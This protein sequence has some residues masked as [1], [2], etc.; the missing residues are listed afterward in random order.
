MNDPRFF[1]D[2]RTAFGVDAEGK[3]RE[4]LRDL[5]LDNFNR[6]TFNSV[7]NFVG[8]TGSLADAANSSEERKA[9]LARLQQ[10]SE[11]YPG[12]FSEGG[13]GLSAVP[14][15]AEGVITD[16]LNVIPAVS[17]SAKVGKGL[18]AARSLGESFTVGR[19]LKEGAL[20]GAK[21]EGLISGAAEGL[22]S[23][24]QQSMRS[25]LGLQD[26]VSGMAV[27]EDVTL[28]ALM[29]AGVGS[30]LGAA[31]G[32][33][34]RS[35]A[36]KAYDQAIDL[37]YR[38]TE[39]MD[40][41]LGEVRQVVQNQR[42]PSPAVLASR[43]DAPQEDLTPE[44]TA[45]M[46]AERAAA[47]A[48]E[49][50]SL[51]LKQHQA[52]LR[53]LLNEYRRQV[54]FGEE[55]DADPDY[56]D[57]VKR[58]LANVR[59]A[60]EFQQ[61]TE[62]ELA[63]II[64]DEGSNKL[65]ALERA[66]KRA[67]VFEEDMAMLDAL[68]TETVPEDYG[69]F[70]RQRLEE[71]KARAEQQKAQQAEQ[72]K[73][74]KKGG[75]PRRG[76]A[77]RTTA[78]GEGAEAPTEAP[79][80]A[81]RGTGSQEGVTAPD[82]RPTEQVT[83]Q[84]PDSTP[85]DEGLDDAGTLDD[86]VARLAELERAEAEAGA[87][88]TGVIPPEVPPK[89]TT[90]SVTREQVRRFADANL[91]DL[92]DVTPTGKDGKV[93][94]GDIRKYLA[95]ET[96][97]RVAEEDFATNVRATT[98]RLVERL[99]EM[100]E[101]IR[102]SFRDDPS[103][104]AR[105]VA[106]ELGV[107]DDAKQYAKIERYVRSAK[108]AGVEEGSAPIKLS[109]AEYERQQ[110]EKRLAREKARKIERLTMETMRD[111]PDMPEIIARDR[112]TKAV[113]RAASVSDTGR[114]RSAQ[115]S[116]ERK[117]I[118]AT[119]DTQKNIQSFMRPGRSYTSKE[120]GEEYS[121]DRGMAPTESEANYQNV[122]TRD[123]ANVIA[124]SK[125]LPAAFIATRQTKTVDSPKV[126]PSGSMLWVSPNG[127]VFKNWRNVYSAMGLESPTKA[128]KHILDEVNRA[129]PTEQNRVRN[130]QKKALDDY[131]AGKIS[132]EKMLARVKRAE[133]KMAS[134]DT[135]IDMPDLV[136]DQGRRLLL[137]LK[138][139]P[140]LT[141]LASKSD[142]DAKRTAQDLVGTKQD[143]EDW[144]A[145][146]VDP[147]TPNTAVGKKAAS[148]GKPQTPAITRYEERTAMNF[149]DFESA[150]LSP[151][152]LTEE[153]WSTL[154]VA[155]GL[156]V[157][158]GDAVAYIDG[159]RASGGGV[160]GRTIQR[161]LTNIELG[162]HR[163]LKGAHKF[164]S[165]WPTSLDAQREL[166]ALVQRLTE[167]RSRLAPYGVALPEADRTI[168]L[169]E[170]EL[171][172]SSFGSEQV[173][174]AK[175]F[176]D[177]LASRALPR[178]AQDASMKAAAET[179][180]GGLR[181]DRIGQVSF[182]TSRIAKGDTPPTATLFHE[183]FHWAWVHVMS[184]A[185]KASVMESLGKYYDANGVFSPL[186][187][188]KRSP[189]EA[190][191][192]RAVGV[193]NALDSPAE[194]LANQFAMWATREVRGDAQ[195]SIWQKATYYIKAVFDRFFAKTSIDPD[196]VPHFARLLPERKRKMAE[197]E[198]RKLDSASGA[199]DALPDA[200]DTTDDV[201]DT[202][203][204]P[205][206][207]TDRRT[208][209]K[210]K[211]GLNSDE[212]KDGERRTGPIENWVRDYTEEE[213]LELA[214]EE[215][216]SYVRVLKNHSRRLQYLDELWD[217]AVA[218]RDV[219]DKA[220]QAAKETLSY[221]Y[222]STF[223]KKQMASIMRR[224]AERA[225][226]PLQSQYG[227]A[228]VL[229][230]YHAGGK[231]RL[232]AHG[233]NK[234]HD[235]ARILAGREVVG[236]S[237]AKEVT[238][239]PFTKKN[240]N[241]LDHAAASVRD[242]D[243]DSLKV[244]A[245]PEEV[246]D[247]L[248]ELF[249]YGKKKVGSGERA[250]GSSLSDWLNLAHKS[251]DTSFERNG[252]RAKYTPASLEKKYLD[253]TKD[254][255]DAKVAVIGNDRKKFHDVRI[256]DPFLHKTDDFVARVIGFEDSPEIGRFAIAKIDGSEATIEISSETVEE[257]K[258]AESRSERE[259]R[260]AQ[261]GRTTVEHMERAS[262]SLRERAAEVRARRRKKVDEVAVQNT[263]RK[264]A[265][266]R[267]ASDAQSMT[268][269]TAMS[270]T[271]LERVIE[272]NETDQADRYAEA[273]ETAKRT[274]VIINPY[275]K[276]GAP[277]RKG[278]SIQ[279][280]DDLVAT[281]DEA[282]RL[283]D[284]DVDAY[285]LELASRNN[286]NPI[287][288]FAEPTVLDAIEREKSFDTFAS[289][290]RGV[291]GNI[292]QSTRQVLISIAHRE[293][294]TEYTARK[295][296]LRFL[297]L[298]DKGDPLDAERVKNLLGFESEPFVDGLFVATGNEAH[299]RF[300]E[301]FRQIGS[302][303]SGRNGDSAE[304]INRLSEIAARLDGD[305]WVEQVTSFFPEEARNIARE[306]P[307]EAISVADMW[308]RKAVHH[309]LHNSMNEAAP[310][311]PMA[312]SSGNASSPD[313]FISRIIDRVGY[314]ANGLMSE[315]VAKTN[316]RLTWYG[317]PFSGDL[318]PRA[319][320]PAN[321]ILTPG[322]ARFAI[323]DVM[324]APPSRKRE[325]SLF[326]GEDIS[327]KTAP[328]MFYRIS[329]KSKAAK[330]DSPSIVSMNKEFGPGVYLQAV[331]SNSIPLLRD[332][333]VVTGE[334]TEKIRLLQ[335]TREFLN[336]ASSGTG[337]SASKSISD[338][339]DREAALMEDLKD[340][341][342][343]DYVVPVIAR[344]TSLLDLGA[345]VSLSE[346]G[347]PKIVSL[348]LETVASGR[349]KG[350]APQKMTK[351][352]ESFAAMV[353]DQAEEID[354]LP[355][356]Y[357]LYERLSKATSRTA[358]SNLFRASGYRG[359]NA[360]DSTVLFDPSDVKLT[361]EPEFFEEFAHPTGTPIRPS[362]PVL[363]RTVDGD[364]SG[365]DDAKA[366]IILSSISKAEPLRDVQHAIGNFV[367]KR[368]PSDADQRAVIRL[369]KNN[370]N[371]GLVRGMLDMLP[372]GRAIG[373]FA[374]GVFRSN[375]NTL[376]VFNAHWLAGKFD[377]Y[378]QRSTQIT[379][380]LLHGGLQDKG[381]LKILRTLPDSSGSVKHAL[382][383][384]Y[385][386]ATADAAG[387]RKF[388]ADQPESHKRIFRWL[389]QRGSVDPQRN[390]RNWNAMSSEEQRAAQ[391]I[392]DH[393]ARTHD[394][395]RRIDPRIGFIK[396]YFPQLW[397]VHK[398][399]K[400]TEDRE[401]FTS[402]L[403]DHFLDAS[404]R[405]GNPL[406]REE[407][408][409]IARRT[410]LKILDDESEGLMVP[411]RGASRNSAAENLDGSRAIR[412]DNSDTSM[413]LREFLEDD[414]EAVMVKYYDQAG[415]RIHQI[416]TFGIGS[417]GAYDYLKV[418]QDGTAGA[419]QLLTT[420]K[421]FQSTKRARDESGNMEEVVFLDTFNMPFEGKEQEAAQV[422]REVEE[423]L[424]DPGLG[425]PVAR[426]IL[427]K[428]QPVDQANGEPSLF[429]ERRVEAILAALSDFDGDPHLITNDAAH[430][431][432]RL[433]KVSNRKTL[434]DHEG[435]L[436]FS[437]GMR[438]F[439]LVT[440]LGFTTLTSLGD[441]VLPLIRSGNMSA[442]AK[443]LRRFA[444]DPV[445][446]EML[447]NIG[448]A[449]ESILHDRLAY[450]WG[451]SDGRFTNA[452]FNA[453]GLTPWTDVNRRF[454]GAVAIETFKAAQKKAHDAWVDGVPFH[455]QPAKV[456][457]AYRTLKNYGL[458]GFTHRSAPMIDSPDVLEGRYT[459]EAI[460]IADSDAARVAV[461]KF[462]DESIFAPNPADIPIWGQTPLG[463]M[464]FQLKSFPLMM[465]R[466][467][468]EIIVDDVKLA[469]YDMLGKKPPSNLKGTGDL[470]RAMW[471]L[472]AA[473]A[474][475]MGSLAVKDIVQG[476]GG[477]R[478]DPDFALRERRF[479]DWNPLMSEPMDDETIDMYAGW[480][481]EGFTH[482]AG[483]GL[484]L[485]MIHDVVSQTDNGAYGQVRVA[486]TLFGPSVSTGV[487]AFN[488]ASGGLDALL[489]RTPDSNST[490]RRGVRSIAERVPVLGGVKPVREMMV[491]L[492]AGEA[493]R[494]RQRQSAKIDPSTLDF[495]DYTRDTE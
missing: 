170:I 357:L 317:N 425:E 14:S 341:L 405:E 241:A 233:R 351:A 255:K 199:G 410:V 251:L 71:R 401:R 308:V 475:G 137:T 228:G 111:N 12:M 118:Y 42:P 215:R 334:V 7:G 445:Y 301:T 348:L 350:T 240:S 338:A 50:D 428:Y 433:M 60:L 441:P 346:D 109:K 451:A 316:A 411:G 344:T 299:K 324:S 417:H 278:A 238:K 211:P 72:Q 387:T 184:D 320:L 207:S 359:F 212:K 399:H 57:E 75:E 2:V 353:R 169:A 246:A 403:R 13:R 100:P 63:Q 481:V 110:T 144:T 40:M 492:A 90:S 34:G 4:E 18:L 429:Y 76:Q 120:T 397:S 484:L 150:I 261:E 276:D 485:E 133:R 264:T 447:E 119:E 103:M 335:E 293:K 363:N 434:S 55:A 83:E 33:I 468:K 382:H 489:D 180:T 292:D 52:K 460:G 321:N 287:I 340:V 252:A 312:P 326:A 198:A 48:R 79:T 332:D 81:A 393:L 44:Q 192:G 107:S 280:I 167:M 275:M 402:L 283:G 173:K 84:V 186:D 98:E 11:K 281:V 130:I 343:D 147:D 362:G 162:A 190:V 311:P 158:S 41:T 153:D 121:T 123:E 106:Q 25:E 77:A 444:S 221:L 21:V 418:M 479:S 423:A 201:D 436:K 440:L 306:N 227:E 37:G 196:L 145:T 389:S 179:A 68:L 256:G 274:K 323:D 467:S 414:L 352:L 117:S 135:P 446:R 204:P 422:I 217:D 416:E 260:L 232:A 73:E 454:A 322:Q 490:E 249:L 318:V 183:I 361:A 176:V 27:L 374:E 208:G 39:L 15:I 239:D 394:A 194:F 285:A 205:S 175:E 220:I 56:L 244:G 64:K 466:M 273:L 267:P 431:I 188:F 254:A 438:N 328:V 122:A 279:D 156:Q 29:G 345:P 224:A 134:V 339:L 398:I 226:T 470:R 271:E 420:K 97:E 136:D 449:G 455:Q 80:E 406:G 195:R 139:D 88:P 383:R 474:A 46:E 295:A 43:S 168:A 395:M 469:L 386:R 288:S 102:A 22:A 178:F 38:P 456:K 355:T 368:A 380:R 49:A 231:N 413:A 494:T 304:A 253:R 28:G 486:S 152:K 10:V 213:L 91:V 495:I 309:R 216:A 305:N 181:G 67:G 141:I 172:F 82:E 286:G 294:R 375:P 310:L 185:D 453:T 370:G 154:R 263:G 140:S 5:V 45:E 297:N 203:T 155:A 127:K 367:R 270:E 262:K 424:A 448:V 391:A 337:P 26:G 319:Y 85:V 200:A 16:P 157:K 330:T 373:N 92:D 378:F 243:S 53:E 245:R 191:N 458:E 408:E 242:L 62:N 377:T 149:A 462:A 327:G 202:P 488:V 104:I 36:S 365:I 400:S 384:W 187:V 248:M 219:P 459:N 70:I 108:E 115:S 360:I 314:M 189:I 349:Y 163:R 30:I 166:L 427:M 1:E 86:F 116:I 419:V 396:D 347:Y 74:A 331:P 237:D 105:A 442:Y 151:E 415:R 229:Y 47:E 478:D 69:A 443:A 430:F 463:A 250:E 112:A 131:A 234:A 247:R 291:P 265:P 333:A 222:G 54:E 8:A 388:G 356:N 491:D 290:E 284:E 329:A 128:P 214:P 125:D 146:Y 336:K 315:P 6:R 437:R 302:G 471:L 342:H 289:S 31:G 313:D 160:N 282:F 35:Q 23:V 452:F 225:G 177:R 66:R 94:Q 404:L 300:V 210:V 95:Q 197:I 461:I 236:I 473:P 366:T 161:L 392:A 364:A 235:I 61:R 174:T 126:S 487:G 358:A 164:M 268:S 171:I 32:A 218:N 407:T 113:E 193:L 159:L 230:A 165:K 272:A 269:A 477:E 258:R 148:S 209:K 450:M 439:N 379:N 206:P 390:K 59:M 17:A 476:R 93:T 129:A 409:E 483:F 132:V 493:E 3:T 19:A 223:S 266:I 182:N 99:D 457:R 277:L 296:A 143:L 307:E 464:I 371:R 259:V 78:K 354:T 101:E 412:L 114:T 20:H 87:A 426:N 369:T 142:I 138:K 472:T 96:P 24:G 298:A 58:R 385:R 89:A 435:M 303:L 376:R 65:D 372:G 482:A 325:M 432:E 124:Q 51:K 421:V 480:V 465:M 257:F 9:A 381:P